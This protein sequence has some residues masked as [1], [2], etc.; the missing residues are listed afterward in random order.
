MERVSTKTT[1][2]ERI[3]YVGDETIKLFE[4]LYEDVKT[5]YKFNNGR[6]V[7]GFNQPYTL[8]QI[9]RRR[10]KAIKEAGLSNAT[11]HDL[12]HM[13]V[14][15]SWSSVPITALSR[16]IGHKNVSVTLERYSHLSQ[17]DNEKMNKYI[18]KSI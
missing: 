12:R 6:Y 7:F 2:S 9:K 1:S 4:T 8:R 14:T 11:N 16:Y 3:I 18:D 5:I 17:E 13:F 10:E 15:N